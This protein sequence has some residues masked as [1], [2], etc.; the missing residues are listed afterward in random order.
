[1]DFKSNDVA[2]IPAREGSVRIP[3]K[4]TKS[5]NGIPLIAYS[6]RSAIDSCLFGEVIVSTDSPEIAKISRDWGA[7]VPSLRPTEYAGST[8]SDIEWV[9]HAFKELISIPQGELG[10]IA[11]LRPTNPL[12]SVDTLRSAMKKFKQST[13]ADSL[14][15]MEVTQVHP[16]KMWRVNSDMEATPYLDQSTETI[17]T[18]NRP[19]QSLERLWVQNAS[20]EIAQSSSVLTTK[21][22]SGKKVL[23]Y[24]MPGFEGFD[25]NTPLDWKLLETLIREKPDMIP[26]M[27][28]SKENI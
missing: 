25:L 3:G 21:S 6:I 7:S 15:A 16:G 28:H 4:N 9:M 17:P 18:H 5:L 2:L 11:I 12:R 19:T 14:R 23:A 8:S 24:E 20:L 22:I 27:T 13:W 1:M 26:K 10:C